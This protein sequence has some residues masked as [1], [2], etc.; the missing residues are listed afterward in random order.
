MLRQQTAVEV[1]GAVI[2]RDD[3]EIVDAGAFSAV[4]KALAR[5][6][7]K[8]ENPAI[9]AFAVLALAGT[10]APEVLRALGFI[11]HLGLRHHAARPRQVIQEVRRGRRRVDPRRLLSLAS[12]ALPGDDR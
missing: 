12:Q 11:D 1:L 3:G 7:H 8:Q 4:P 10:G 2:S 6:S 9:T 5:R